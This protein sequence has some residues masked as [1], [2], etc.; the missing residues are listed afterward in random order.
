MTDVVEA[1]I[2]SGTEGKLVRALDWKGAFWV[3]AGVPPLVLF[4][5]G[6]IAGTTGKLAFVVW[7][8]SMVMGFLQSFT[9]AEIAGMFANKSGGAS[10]Y[11]ATAWLRYS[12][13]IAPLSVWC[14]WFAWSPVLSLGCAIAAGYI[15][16]A[17]FP[18]PA[19]DSQM[20][21]DW[22]S[23]HAASITADSPRVA[24][25]IAAHAGTTPDDA[26]KALLGTDGVAALTPWIRSWSLVS[27]SIPFLA[28]ANVNATFFIGGILMLIIFA[29]QHRGISE[30]ASVQKWLAIIVLVPLLIIGLYPIVS[31]H[32]LAANVTGLVPPTAAYSGA[33]GTWSNGGWT[34]FLGGLYIAAWSTYGFETA[35][36]YTRELKNPKTDTFKAI[37]YS[38]LACCLFFFL[39]PFAFQ[40]VLGHAGMLAP[41]IVDGTGVAEA[42]G[43]LIGAGR[44]ITQLLVVLMIMALFLAIMT[45]MA[46]SSRTLY[47]GSKDGWLP[48]YLD[49]VN[50]NGAPTRAMWTDFAFNLFL[51]AIASDTGGYFFVLAVSNVG[52]IIFNFLN[53]N[54]GWIHR[55]DSG[56]IERPWKAPT[57][58]IGL[59]TVL[60][61][62]NALFL[63]AGAKVWGYSNALWV[64]FIFAAL[65]L[66]VFAYRHYVRDGGK[67]PAGAMEDLGLVGQDL[68]VKKAGILPYLALAAGL[69]IVLIANV[70]FQLPA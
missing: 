59:N 24:E 42:L 22:I 38:G 57:W 41:G 14:N 56:H 67:F 34:L 27:F 3:A 65:I 49:H 21:L 8:I 29:I 16:N 60:A 33:D 40:G 10:V 50:E 20:V 61:F 46:G 47:Q 51:L 44:V 18:I 48:K 28:T 25:Y 54:S 37:F 12:K 32:I 62:V 17:F 64:G 35:V 55:M 52:Y 6:G 69:A 19:A 39:V 15:L 53:L 63:G 7:I 70:I 23:A 36:C 11:G 31:G 13:F 1:G 68:G 43:G 66:P 26:V 45:A 30:T 2:S 5:I 9:Y 4:S 58:L